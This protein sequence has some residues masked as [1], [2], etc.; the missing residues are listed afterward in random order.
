[1]DYELG[2]LHDDAASDGISDIEL[3][4][5]MACGKYGGVASYPSSCNFDTLV[6]FTS[7]SPRTLDN[8]S[9]SEPDPDDRF[10]IRVSPSIITHTILYHTP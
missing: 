3:L 7:P 6:S 10:D 9:T 5:L 2:L 1:M 4:L 8:T